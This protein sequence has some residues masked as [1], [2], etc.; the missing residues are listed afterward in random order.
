MNLVTLICN[1]ILWRRARFPA[2]KN[3]HKR[4]RL[5]LVEKKKRSLEEVNV[6][7][8]YYKQFS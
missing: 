5:E 8:S 1:K 6:L 2:K 7:Q 3:S 4:I